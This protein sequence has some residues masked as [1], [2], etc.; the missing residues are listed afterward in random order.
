MATE[1]L[2]LRG[3]LVPFLYTLARRAHDT[4]HADGA[5]RCTCAGPALDDAYR[6]DRQYMLGPDVLVA[7]VAAAGDPAQKTRV[8]PA[9]AVGRLLHRRAPPRA[10]GS[11]GCR[12]RWSGC[13]CSCA[14]ARSC[15]RRNTARTRPTRAPDPLVLTAWAGRD[16]GFRLYEDSGDGLEYRRRSF[17]FTRIV[18]DDRG[19]VA[20]RWSRSAGRAGATAGR[21]VRRRYELRVVGARLPRRVTVAGR[22]IRRVRPGSARG[23]WYERATRTAVVRTGRL[24]TSRRARIGLRMSRPR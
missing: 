15:P 20:G 6:H 19:Q 9:R 14:P 5:R 8:V 21:P 18:H 22:G 24:P 17:A 13:R 16:G 1:F 23:W 12:C 10:G 4:G 11:S 3:R 7:P 2:R